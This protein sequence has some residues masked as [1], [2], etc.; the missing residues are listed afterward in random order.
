MPARNG[1]SLSTTTKR[2]INYEK[3]ALE[4]LGY[5]VTTASSS[6]EALGIFKRSP[7]AFDLLITDQTMPDMTGLELARQ[8]ASIK[9][10]L[11]AVL[12]TGYSAALAEETP[13][14]GN[15]RVVASKPFTTNELAQYVRKALD[16]RPASTIARPT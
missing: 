10:G 9:P 13:R 1:S 2:I 5:T 14:P 16:D 7:E 15:I 8:V 4:G 11:P 12:C 6:T 3:A